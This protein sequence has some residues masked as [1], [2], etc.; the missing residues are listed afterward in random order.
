MK[1]GVWLVLGAFLCGGNRLSGADVDVSKLPPPAEVKVDFDRDV[2][3]IFE[4]SCFRCHGPEKP[5]SKFRLD[6]RESALKGGENN[7][8]DIVPGDSAKSRLIHYVARLAE[9]LEM[10][11]EGK[12]EPLTPEQVGLLRAWIDQGAQWPAGSETAQRAAT[13]SV[14][15]TLSYIS[16]SGDR[17]KFREDWGQKEGFSAGYEH[18]ELR[19]PVGKDSEFS[20]E[21]RA[22]FDQNDYRVTLQLA[23]PDVGF[24]RGGY[25]TYRKY[26]DDSGGLYRPFNQPPPSLDQDLHLDVGRTWFDVGLTL[27]NLPKVVLGYEYQF[28]NGDMATLQWGPEDTNNI[29]KSIRPSAKQLDE[30][31]HILKLDVTHEISGTFLEDNFRAEFYDLKTR[32][33]HQGYYFDSSDGAVHNE[34]YDHFQAANSLRAEKQIRDWLFVS[35]GY[36]YTRLNGAGDFDQTFNPPLPAFPPVSADRIAL[37]QHSHTFNLNSRLGPWEGLTVAAGA[38]SDWVRK[39]GVANF[40]VGTADAPNASNMDRAAVTEHALLQYDR[41]PFTV[42]YADAT[43]RQEWIDQ[44]ETG[45]VNDSVSDAQDFIRDTDARGDLREY[46]GGFTFSPWPRVSLDANY[47]HRDDQSDYNHLTDTNRFQ[48]NFF[49]RPNAIPGNGYPAFIRSRDITSDEVEFKLVLKLRP[50]LKTTLKY[51]LVATD[52][53]SV[54]ASATNAF[55]TNIYAGGEILAGN[56]DARVYSVNTTLTPW[57]RLY[58][59]TTFSYSDSRIMSE[60]NYGATV[61]PYRG[62]VYSVLSSGNIVVSAKTDFHATYSFSRADY[63]QDNEAL[64]LPL[65]IRYSRHALTAGITRRISKNVSGTLQYG[66]FRYREPTAAGANDYTAHAVLASLN[67]RI[68]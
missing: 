58:L 46:R 44:F 32:R 40:N 3:P 22:M 23:R 4:S 16:V 42:V 66:Y 67:L 59:S 65:G 28:R 13:F 56:Q 20:V 64:G 45:L 49:G 11:P 34:S 5:K 7:K 24:V 57:R 48:T 39:N 37:E 1:P 38:Q 10:P 54:T 15:P 63:E 29:I 9:D 50:W 2:R 31:V 47:R 26:F 25:E 6:N 33:E 41:I 52:Y 14:T 35:G 27:P 51:Q 55:N 18:F 61:A 36:L 30:Q 21:G 62:D 8:D 12:G 43:A 53:D 17:N 68:P 60:A 19:E